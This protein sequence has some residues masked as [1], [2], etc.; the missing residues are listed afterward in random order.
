[1]TAVLLLLQIVEITGALVPRLLR[2]M[3]VSVNMG[4]V[5]KWWEWNQD[6]RVARRRLG[7]PPAVQ[8]LRD[9]FTQQLLYH[10]CCSMSLACAF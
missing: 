5:L 7:D 3:L 1:M 10:T 4:P 8:P 9:T 6:A 2:R